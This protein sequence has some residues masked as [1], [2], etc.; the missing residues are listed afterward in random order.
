MEE[1]IWSGRSER[2]DYLNIS[3]YM[4]K[5]ELNCKLRVSESNDPLAAHSFGG[6]Q[7]ANGCNDFLYFR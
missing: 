2:N 3:K 4:Q 6:K 7:K 1:K 5:H